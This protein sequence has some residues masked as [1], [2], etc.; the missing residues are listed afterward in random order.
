MRSSVFSLLFLLP[1][2]VSAQIT[3]VGEFLNFRA[4]LLFSPDFTYRTLRGDMENNVRQL[5]DH[6][7]LPKTGFTGGVNM[8]FRFHKKL[9]IEGGF[10]YSNKGER[11][12][13][14]NYNLIVF[15]ED[16]PLRPDMQASFINTYRYLDLPIK[17]N[18]YLR[19]KHIAIYI[20]AGISPNI[21]LGQST[22]TVIDTDDS[23]I[24]I[25]RTLRNHN[26]SSVDLAGLIALGFD[27]KASQRWSIRFE[28]TF[29]HS[30]RSIMDTTLRT[31]LYSAGVNTGVYLML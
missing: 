31:Y 23:R 25:R 30:L 3:E 18:Y 21:F 10:L 14:G 13:T 1:F 29:R 20:S 27:I 19:P 8:I 5:R 24:H 28:P 6:Y 16:D 11:T 22:T 2:M 7:E 12:K 15:N 26:F 17:L 9:A 4:G